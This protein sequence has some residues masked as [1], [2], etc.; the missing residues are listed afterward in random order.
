MTGQPTL[1]AEE[2]FLAASEMTPAERDE[3]VESECGD[4]ASLRDEVKGLL[5]A[6][7]G[8]ARY[9]EHLPDRLGVSKLRSGTSSTYS[10]ESGQEFR[11][12]SAYRE[13]GCRWHG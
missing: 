2:I 7:E 11:P 13:T 5:G 3:Y 9:F 1:R 10:A 8:S 6:A 4:D 12:L